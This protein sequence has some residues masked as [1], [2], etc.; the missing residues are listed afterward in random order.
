MTRP[1]PMP[2]ADQ[3]ERDLADAVVLRDRNDIFMRGDLK[4]AVGRRVDD[5]LAGPHVFRAEARR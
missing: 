5:R 2:R 3:I 1:T 4:H